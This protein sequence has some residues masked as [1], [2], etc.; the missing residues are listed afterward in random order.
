MVVDLLQVYCDINFNIFIG[1]CLWRSTSYFGCKPPSP[2]IF[3]IN[4]SQVFYL[5]SINSMCRAIK[6]TQTQ[7]VSALGNLKSTIRKTQ[8]SDGSKG[9]LTSQGCFFWCVVILHK[10]KCNFIEVICGWLA[11]RKRGSLENCCTKEENGLLKHPHEEEI[12][13]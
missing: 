13:E 7:M 12:K 2:H 9:I 4:S 1:E 11:F 8:F 10:S 3:C 6:S 5:L